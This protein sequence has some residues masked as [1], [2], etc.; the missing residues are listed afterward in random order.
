MLGR[1]EEVFNCNLEKITE[2]GGRRLAHVA[3]L[4]R[5]QYDRRVLTQTPNNPL[6]EYVAEYKGTAIFSDDRGEFIER[7]QE[8]RVTSVTRVPN[9]A[10]NS[11]AHLA[12]MQIRSSQTVTLRTLEDRERERLANAEEQRRRAASQPAS[13]PAPA[14]ATLPTGG[15]P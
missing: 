10:P 5:L 6:T 13:A 4:D 1:V 9:T 8:G 3:Y 2:R 15:R 12:T 14:A 7:S 11:S